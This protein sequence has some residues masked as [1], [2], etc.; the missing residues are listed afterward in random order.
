VS[1]GPSV[2]VAVRAG[3]FSLDRPRRP[4]YSRGHPLTHAGTGNE[5]EAA[6]ALARAMVT[7]QIDLVYGGASVGAMGVLA[8]TVLAEG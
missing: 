6:K 5:A 8:D 4:P 1:A 2:Q 7:R 3:A